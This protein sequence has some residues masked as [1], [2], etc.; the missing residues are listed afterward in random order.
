MTWV[1]E[2]DGKYMSGSHFG[3]NQ[4]TTYHWSKDLKN[5]IPITELNSLAYTMERMSRGKLVP[6]PTE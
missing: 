6:K 3:K 4:R 5:A 2:K 1:I